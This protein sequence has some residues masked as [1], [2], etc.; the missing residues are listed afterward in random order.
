[1]L[2]IIISKVF[3]NRLKRILTKVI[4][5]SQSAFVLGRLITNNV[6]VAFEMMQCIDQ[7]RKGR[8]ALM[9]VKLDMSKAYEPRS[10]DEENGLPRYLTQ[11]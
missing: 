10:H 11:Y 5:V 6:L 7:R 1:M 2:Y 4:D 3:A 8:E 9:V